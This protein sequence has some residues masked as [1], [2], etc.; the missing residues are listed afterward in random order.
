MRYILHR[1]Y[2]TGL[3]G[4]LNSCSTSGMKAAINCLPELVALRLL[5]STGAILQDEKRMVSY[6]QI[7]V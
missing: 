2:M 5:H 7:I 1:Y 3:N 6:Q 4:A